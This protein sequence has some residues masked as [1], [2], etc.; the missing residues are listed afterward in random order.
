MGTRR[1]KAKRVLLL[2]QKSHSSWCLCITLRL[3]NPCFREKK[4]A[5]AFFGIQ[6]RQETLNRNLNVVCQSVTEKKK[7]KKNK[8][9]KTENPADTLRIEIRLVWLFNL[10]GGWRF[11]LPFFFIFPLSLS[12]IRLGIFKLSHWK[13]GSSRTT[14]FPFLQE[15]YHAANTLKLVEE[16]LEGNIQIS[17]NQNES[18]AV[19]SLAE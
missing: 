9:K 3:C 12:S 17:E 5:S 1:E 7:Q 19:T 4:G 15:K 16:K 11:A 18:P 2:T 14:H 6:H 8:K 10:I 13:Q